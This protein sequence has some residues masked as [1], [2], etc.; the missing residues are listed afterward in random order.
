EVIEIARDDDLRVGVERQNAGDE[1]MDDLRL[2]MPL[3][4]GAP[5]GW[6]E[7][8]KEG[9]IA[10][11][12]VEVVR[13][14]EEPLPVVEKLASQRLAAVVEGR[15]G[16]VDAA[17]AEGELGPTGAVHHRRGRGGG[18]TGPVDEAEAAVGAEEETDPNVAARLAP[19]GVVHRID[20]AE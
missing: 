7:A 4:L 6:L 17:R 18:P 13:D 9:L 20:L 14:D 11:L 10:A 19:V 15:V 12:R 2:L 5:L 3:D 8:P 1:V 16:W